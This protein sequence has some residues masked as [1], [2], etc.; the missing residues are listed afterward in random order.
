[1]QRTPSAHIPDPLRHT[2]PASCPLP[3]TIPSRVRGPFLCTPT[4][5]SEALSAAGGGVRGAHTPISRGAAGP[6]PPRRGAL[7]CREAGSGAG[8]RLR[9]G[10]G[11]AGGRAAGGRAGRWARESPAPIAELRLLG[12]LNPS[13]AG[14]AR[15]PARPRASGPVPSVGS[16]RGVH[17]GCRREPEGSCCEEAARA[18]R[19]AEWVGGQRAGS[20]CNPGPAL[21]PP[22][23][24]GAP[25][26]AT[27]SPGRRAGGWG[28]RTREI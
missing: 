3:H 4:Q 18:G 24:G 12:P 26:A 14:R 27:Q 23:P 28:E 10:S 20:P 21:A 22:P 2:P 19:T 16:V 9:G 15:P 25:A 7:T 11:P 6:E 8:P 5:L 13:A 17:A 1:V